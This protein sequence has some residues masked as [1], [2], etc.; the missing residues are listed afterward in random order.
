MYILSSGLHW[1]LQSVKILKSQGDL[2]APDPLSQ[3]QWTRPSIWL[4]RKSNKRFV[5]LW[6]QSEWWPSCYLSPPSFIPETREQSAL[7]YVQIRC[8]KYFC[9]QIFSSSNFLSFYRKFLWTFPLL[10]W[11]YV[12]DTLQYD[13]SIISNNRGI[14]I[15]QFLK[16]NIMCI[17]DLLSTI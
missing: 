5:L 11:F 7:V 14:K 15:K 16:K 12:W 13:A 2:W 3:P 6:G 4:A 1:P 9:I 17:W 8:E 10:G